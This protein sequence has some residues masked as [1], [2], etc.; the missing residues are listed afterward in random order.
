M[1]LLDKKF[2]LYLQK[3]LTNMKD[4]EIIVKDNNA[5]MEPVSLTSIESLIFNIRGQQVMFDKDLAT[6]YGV[7]TKRLNEQV[8]RNIKDFRRI[9]CSN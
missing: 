4:G 6:L 9:L 1:F 3:P 8:K 5:G 7:S 2:R